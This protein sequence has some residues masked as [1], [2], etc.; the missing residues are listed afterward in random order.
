M[1]GDELKTELKTDTIEVRFGKLNKDL[2]VSEGPK[3]K[4]YRVQDLK[5]GKMVIIKLSRPRYET[6]IRYEYDLLMRFKASGSKI[7]Q[8]LDILMQPYS[9]EELKEEIRNR[10]AS[11]NEY[12]EKIKNPQPYD[13]HHLQ[14]ILVLEEMDD[15]LFEY[16]ENNIQLGKKIEARNIMW[17]VCSAVLEC[18]KMGIIHRDLKPENF[19]IKHNIDGNTITVK[20]GDFDLSTLDTKEG[21][22]G[23]GT[24]LFRSP[25]LLNV[26]LRKAGYEGEI[27]A[28]GCIF[29]RILDLPLFCCE[30]FPTYPIIQESEEQAIIILQLSTS[31]A[32]CCDWMKSCKDSSA[33]DLLC[34]MLTIDYKNRIT[35]ED[36]LLH[37]YF[38]PS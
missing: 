30:Y 34:K 20:L 19:F 32:I 21:R 14:V 18:K 28:V 3:S 17:Q 8:V 6:H 27:W 31:S 24:Q 11:F 26:N 33:K 38:K 12:G 10:P 35:I 1:E 37:P 23:L 7:V 36:V 4:V 2:I 29:A 5:T 13:S 9:L 15:D 22:Y 25:E 16:L